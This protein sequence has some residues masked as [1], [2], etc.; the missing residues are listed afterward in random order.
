M[1]QHYSA[2]PEINP[3]RRAKQK[4]GRPA[5]AAGRRIG[6]ARTT[7]FSQANL[8]V[9]PPPDPQIANQPPPLWADPRTV[10]SPE[11]LAKRRD[12]IV[13]EV[14]RT[15]S[16]GLRSAMQALAGVNSRIGEQQALADQQPG[17]PNFFTPNPAPQTP[18]VMGNRQA[19]D[20]NYRPWQPNIG[21]VPESRGIGGRLLVGDVDRLE[22]EQEKARLQAWEQTRAQ[23]QVK[24]DEAGGV[25]QAQTMAM[26]AAGQR[27]L[28]IES[29]TRRAEPL[30]DEATA[31]LL[32][33]R[34]ERVSG[35]TP[36]AERRENVLRRANP[37]AFAR[38]DAEA[39]FTRLEQDAVAAR[40]L[41][42]KTRLGVSRFGAIGQYTQ[43]MAASQQALPGVLP[44]WLAGGEAAGQ[45][46]GLSAYA[47]QQANILAEQYEGDPFGYQNALGSLNLSPS[48]IGELVQEH[49]PT[50]PS[51]RTRIP[52][53]FNPYLLTPE[54]AEVTTETLN[55]LQEQ[56]D[57]GS[58][59][60]RKILRRHEAREKE[61]QEEAAKR[62]RRLHAVPTYGVF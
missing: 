40:E 55:R 57:A 44:S 29:G 38:R 16:P 35:R 45:P 32:A 30:S 8:D 12:K 11:S 23:Q 26:E 52:G 39:Q 20:P 17:T 22:N 28:A 19:S 59:D 43:A 13:G 25:L 56:A 50:P 33:R 60:A 36:L 24:F 58:E 14:D 53:A 21:G 2:L 9:P 51:L 5:K 34:K 4:P 41:E 31:H 62:K 49:F 6:P 37:Q 42:S 3:V 18:M 61:K 46:T 48:E 10:F 1:P 7:P 15:L 27:R 54:P 47:K